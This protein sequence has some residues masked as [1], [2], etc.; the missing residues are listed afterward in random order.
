[1]AGTA[2]QPNENQRRSF[3]RGRCR[4][5]AQSQQLG[6]AQAAKTQ[7]AE[8]LAGWGRESRLM[9][10]LGQHLGVSDR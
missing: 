6:Q 8:T 3:T 5:S 10:A 2:P 9:A 7:G 4:L 1:M